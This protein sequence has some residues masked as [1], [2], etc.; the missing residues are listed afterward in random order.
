VRQHSTR[1]L[2]GGI[3]TDPRSSF[4]VAAFIKGKRVA[5]FGPAAHPNPPGDLPSPQSVALHLFG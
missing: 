4:S 2:V 1:S 5:D 3:V